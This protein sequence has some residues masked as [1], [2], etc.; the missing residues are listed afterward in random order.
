MRRIIE[1][2]LKLVF[3]EKCLGCR[4]RGFYLCADCLDRIPP[5]EPIVDLPALACFD[6]HDKRIKRAIWLLKYKGI[7]SL[8][9]L[10]AKLL[11]DKLIEQLADEVNILPGLGSTWLVSPIS[12][13]R[14]RQRERGYNQAALIARELVKLAPDNLELAENILIKIKHTPTQVSISNRRDRLNNLKDAFALTVDPHNRPSGSINLQGRRIILVDDVITTGATIRE[15]MRL[16]K[17]AGAKSVLGIA[18]A[19]G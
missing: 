6:Y 1:K 8:A 4:S 14:E 10:F 5:A 3:P 17:R 11:Y 9:P 13:S 12:L 19:H 15:A 16:L 18:I 2:V 7:S